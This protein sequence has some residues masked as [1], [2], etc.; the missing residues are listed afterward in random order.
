MKIVISGG[1]TM[2]H[3]KPA[4]CLASS[5]DSCEI[6][7]IGNINE[8]EKFKG[9]KFYGIKMKGLSKNPFKLIEAMFLLIV[10]YFKVKKIYI[11]EKPDMV[12]GF[13]GY[14]TAPVLLA[15]KRRKIKYFIHEQ[16]AVLGLVN[17]LTVKKANLIF[18]SFNLEGQYPNLKWTGNPVSDYIHYQ[19]TGFSYDQRPR[20][21]FIGGSLGASKINDLAIALKNDYQ[22][23]LISGKR[24]YTSEEGIRIIPY[25]DDL[26]SLMI[27]SDLIVSR[28]GATTMAEIIAIGKPVIFIP[29]PNVVHNHQEI[30]ASMLYDLGACDMILEDNSTK[31]VLSK[32]IDRILNNQFI[33]ENM[34]IVQRKIHKK[35]VCKEINKYLFIK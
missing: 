29:S 3:I 31:E 18:S 2:G 16:N 7:F 13:G 1:G 32:R 28:S 20:I 17:R 10:S 30:N 9:N 21:L 25:I 11:N 19:P 6:I 27:E 4:L 15:A 22:I 8:E 26:V 23:T 35:N 24:F 14:V 33:K 5:L 12:V 34:V